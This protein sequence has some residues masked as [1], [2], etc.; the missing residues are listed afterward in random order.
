MANL[1]VL[2]GARAGAV[3]PL[4]G[5]LVVGRGADADL[6]LK[7]VEV[8]GRHCRLRL[9]ETTY[10][11]DDL[12]STNGTFCNGRVVEGS[13]E[14]Q[15]GD[16][17]QVG[18]TKL[19][20]TAR[21][22]APSRQAS[23]VLGG[24]IDEEPTSPRVHVVGA[25]RE[26]VLLGDSDPF[27]S[28][29]LAAGI[30]QALV[31]VDAVQRAWSQAAGLDDLVQRIASSFAR[32]TAAEHVFVSLRDDSD[33][34]RIVF[35]GEVGPGE[36]FLPTPSELTPR[37]DLLTLAHQR[38]GAF[39]AE[40]GQEATRHGLGA[41]RDLCLALP[42][43]AGLLG[44]V[45]LHGARGLSREDLRL[46]LLLAGLAGAQLRTKQLLA[47]LQEQRREQDLPSAGAPELDQVQSAIVTLSLEG[48]VVSWNEGA[49]ELYGHQAAE[50]VGELLPT[51]PDEQGSSLEKVLEAVATGRA[52]TLRSER[53]T[54]DGRRLAIE[55]TYAPIRDA[56]GEVRGAI[57]IA[58]DLG[59]QLRVERQR[60][61]EAQ[62]ASVHSLAATLAHE[63]G[64]PL[65]NLRGGIDWLLARPRSE[66]ERRDSLVTLRDEIDRLHR[67]TQ[68]A[69]DL[70]RFEL[71]ELA[72]LTVEELLS[73]AA[74]VAGPRAE[75]QG[76]QLLLP[77]GGATSLRASSDQLK[78]ALLNLV[79]NALAAM[80]AGGALELS[81]E[82]DEDAVVIL[83]SDTGTGIPPDQ[84]E[85]VFEPFFTTRSEGSGVGLA[86]VRRI[87]QL[88]GGEA[89]IES[90]PEGTT[91]CLR[92]PRGIA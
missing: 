23:P 70:A 88:H 3:L 34:P 22:E 59:P 91:A 76:V 32:A 67:I 78:Q 73:Y 56:E 31:A 53:L 7:D 24:L 28:D 89:W 77:E 85:R 52:L 41:A 87:A 2:T 33:E 1:V 64:N 54:V 8:S 65:A 63:L 75:E 9:H 44:A 18:S 61:I 51:V 5:E 27:G 6:R 45:Y 57:E 74:A 60:S 48:Q 17:I 68:S 46:L 37:M 14:L 30:G 15:L 36:G 66:E 92:L 20:Y 80:P 72:V 29:P 12:G 81:C 49:Q 16:V 40:A 84:L 26:E 55:A 47:R 19:L 69:L 21:G 4:R 50:V 39:L 38:R 11:L 25:E 71:P 10:T 90:S 83:V 86:T 62:Q 42:S 58:R 79:D 35:H 13:L 43:S 82:L